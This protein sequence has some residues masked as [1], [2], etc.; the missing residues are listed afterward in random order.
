MATNPTILFSAKRYTLFHQKIY[1][2]P[3]K[4]ILFS[5]KRYTLFRQKIYSFLDRHHF[6]PSQGKQMRHDWQ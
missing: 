3:S 6:C 1:S 2:F 5:T 4:D